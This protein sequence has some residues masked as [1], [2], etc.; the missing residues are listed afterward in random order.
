MT[1]NPTA[2][3]ESRTSTARRE[4]RDRILCLE[5]PPGESFSEGGLAASLDMGRTP[6]REALNLLAHE[7]LVAVAPHSGYRVVP[8]TLRD[9]RELLELRLPVEALAARLVA[10]RR[11]AAGLRELVETAG[12]EAPG[13]DPLPLGH[14]AFSAALAAR[15]GNARAAE[16]GEY[17]LHHQVRHLHLAAALGE[18]GWPTP[19]RRALLAAIEAGD[20]DAAAAAVETELRALGAAVFTALVPVVAAHLDKDPSTT[21]QP[22]DL[23]DTD[24]GPLLPPRP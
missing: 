2:R 22:D 10:R 16:V 3:A 20:Q 21:T 13:T 4:I 19:D 8:V 5:M 18:P 23:L 11:D 24:L 17:A 14:I 12:A 15:A 6:V 1:A 9:V 7:G